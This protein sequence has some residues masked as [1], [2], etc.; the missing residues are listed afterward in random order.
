[1]FDDKLDKKIFLNLFAI[2]L[3][4]R[5][6]LTRIYCQHTYFCLYHSFFPSKNK[7][8]YFAVNNDSQSSY[9]IQQLF[10]IIYQAV[11]Y[12]KKK[13]VNYIHIN[14]ATCIYILHLII[15]NIFLI[16]FIIKLICFI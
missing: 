11:F 9:L 14:P 10:N 16:K 6:Y 12:E 8:K 15:V 4:H 13:I 5:Y 7:T 2:M 3:L 1:M